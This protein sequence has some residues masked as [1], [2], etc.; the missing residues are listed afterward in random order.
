MDQNLW[1]RAWNSVHE[2]HPQM[3]LQQLIWAPLEL[4]V[5]L[6]GQPPMTGQSF[7]LCPHLR[8][9]MGMKSSLSSRTRRAFSLDDCQLARASW[10]A[11]IT[12]REYLF[13]FAWKPPVDQWGHCQWTPD[14]VVTLRTLL[15][16]G[17]IRLLLGQ[18]ILPR[19]RRGHHF[20]PFLCLPVTCN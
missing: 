14:V 16:D 8:K 2:E 19:E 1:R 18:P 13:L 4:L 11:V 7:Q 9:Y 17:H 15:M 6:T 5:Y 3:F 20:C 10:W 12:Q